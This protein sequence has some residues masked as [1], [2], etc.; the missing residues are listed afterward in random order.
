MHST[1]RRRAWPTCLAFIAA[2]SVA[3]GTPTVSAAD[4]EAAEAAA[5]V[6][7]YDADQVPTVKVEPL[8]SRAE[9]TLEKV[10]ITYAGDEAIPVLLALPK[11]GEG[12]FPLVM[13]LHGHG[14]DK[15]KMIGLYAGRLARRGIAS[16]AYDLAGHGDRSTVGGSFLDQLN[17]GDLIG[18]TGGVAQSVIDGR[19]VLDYLGQRGE[20]DLQRTAVL[21]YSLGSYIGC[22]LTNVDSR[23]GGLVINVCGTNRRLVAAIE[24]SRLVAGLTRAFLP[25]VHAPGIAPRPVLML[26]G[27]HDRVVP[28]TDARI[29]YNA[30]G[31]PK[32]IIWYDSGHALPL[33]AITVAVNWLDRL[34]SSRSAR[35]G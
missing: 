3:C 35:A 5:A 21:G 4:R 12:P 10:T 22:I 14:G 29:L 9:Y 17:R 32:R 18:V 28:A 20:F 7:A 16:A 25:T 30:F 34:F 31:Q 19:R 26:N 8:P 13:L 33:K 6:F 11:R 24:R 27:R 2:S 23:V 15:T 1:F